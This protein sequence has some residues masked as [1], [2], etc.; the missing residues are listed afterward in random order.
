MATDT[1]LS[2]RRLVLRI[3]S[4]WRDLGPE[5]QMPSL[6]CI[7]AAGLGR[8]GPTCFILDIT[9]PEPIFAFMGEKHIAHHGSD[10]TG[11]P[12]EEV[13]SGS[14]LGRAVDYL[15]EILSRKIP[16]TY[17]GTFIGTDGGPVLYRSIMLPL[18]DDGEVINGILG[19]ANC[20]L[21]VFN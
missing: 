13:G 16:I 3:L 5:G 17:G 1:V 19:G 15:D 6:S 21:P 12:I 11:R 9:G 18:S 14:L 20:N 2:E 10:L 8:L 7:E 4:F